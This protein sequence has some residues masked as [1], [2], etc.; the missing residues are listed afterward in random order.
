MA[1]KWVVFVT[2]GVYVDVDESLDPE[3]SD[4]DYNQLRTLAVHKMWTQGYESVRTEAEIEF[5]DVT[6]E[7]AELD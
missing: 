7:F 4:E 3:N 5:E 1:Q 6:K 2:Q